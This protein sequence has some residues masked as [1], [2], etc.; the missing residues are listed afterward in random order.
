MDI[1]PAG[2]LSEATTPEPQCEGLE[3]GHGLLSQSTA[4]AEVGGVCY[5]RHETVWL[6][7]GS[8][9][10]GASGRSKTKKVI[11]KSTEGGAVS[12]SAVRVIVVPWVWGPAVTNWPFLVL[13]SAGVLQTPTWIQKLP[14][15]LFLANGYQTVVAIEG[16]EQWTFYFSI[17]LCPFKKKKV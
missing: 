14:Q 9:A 1:S 4:V 2:S 5:L 3:P 7:P 10:D 17:W 8:L 15:S 11:A 13:G 6:L 16:Y 12:G